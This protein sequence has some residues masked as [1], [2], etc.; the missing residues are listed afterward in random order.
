MPF[1][2]QA[3]MQGHP[4]PAEMPRVRAD[5]NAQ[6]WGGGGDTA[7]YVFD[8]TALA[9]AH[10]QPGKHVFLW[11]DDGPGTVLGWIGALE[12]VQLGKF[13]GWR[14]V[15]IPGSFYRGPSPTRADAV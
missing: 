5:L 15:P 10:P 3:A 14:A 2:D 4:P 8:P 7:F 11:D 6:G 12:H 13:T 1:N 9:S